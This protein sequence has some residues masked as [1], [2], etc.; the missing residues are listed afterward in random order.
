[1]KIVPKIWGKE[2][3]ITNEKEYCGK[4]LFIRKGCQS[5]LH[6]HKKKK[7]TFFLISG[8]VNLEVGHSVIPIKDMVVIEP[9]TRHRFIGV[10]DAVLLEVSTHHDENDVV[11]IEIS[12][13]VK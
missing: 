10:T 6:Y 12:L 1:M 4:L 2:Y 13:G 9:K 3:W 5:S 11:R 7:E 8:D